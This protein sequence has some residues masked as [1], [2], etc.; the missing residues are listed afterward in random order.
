MSVREFVA[1]HLFAKTI[2]NG[3]IYLYFGFMGTM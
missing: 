1:V 2:T 3:G